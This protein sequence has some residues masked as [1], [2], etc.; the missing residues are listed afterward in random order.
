LHKTGK[1]KLFYFVQYSLLTTAT[2]I[3]YNG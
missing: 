1:N 2:P 3:V